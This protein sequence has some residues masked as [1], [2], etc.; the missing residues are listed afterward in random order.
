MAAQ[1]K[2]V[3]IGT[4]YPT[5]EYEEKI[6]KEVGAELVLSEATTE[7]EV[8]EAVRDADGILN[9]TISISAEAIDAMEKCRVIARY[10]VGYDNVDVAAATKKGICVANVPSYCKDEV[11]EQAFALLLTCIR[12]TVEHDRLIR[13]G[14]WD[15]CAKYPMYRI[16][17]KTLGLLGLGQI[18]RSLAEKAS[19][20]G[21][22]M[23]SHDPYVKPE[24][25][26]ACNVELVEL[27]TLWKDSDYISIHAPATESTR[28]IVNDEAFGLMKKTVI[29]VNT[30]RGALIDEK[31]LEAALRD[32]LIGGAG[33]DVFEVEPLPA[34]SPLRQY[35]NVVLSD[36]EG[37][38]SEESQ[39]DLQTLASMEVARVLK[40]GLPESLV[41]PDVKEIIGK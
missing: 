7:K 13:K 24:Q 36:H 32:G 10:G 40:G 23:I 4:G 22:R 20:L 38:Y 12:R 21:V 3:V 11:A 30:S 17:G 29:I 19:G 5:Y 15:I 18:A 6:L 1:F 16:R 33:L 37:W 35:D 9:R 28:H 8:A 27:E 2:V 39:V 14:E 25:A 26:K 34:D 31:A 41:N